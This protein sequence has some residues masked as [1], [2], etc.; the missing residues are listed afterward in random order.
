METRAASARVPIAETQPAIRA[1]WR[2]Y[3]R[4]A[5]CD[6]AEAAAKLR[7]SVEYAAAWLVQVAYQQTQEAPEITRRA[8]SMVQL[9]LNILQRPETAA[10]ELLGLADAL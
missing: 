2:S 6:E 5:G 9:G 8:V 1:F 10:R 3:I 7:R 4:R